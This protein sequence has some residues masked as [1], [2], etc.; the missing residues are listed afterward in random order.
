MNG[1]LAMAG[2]LLMLCVGPSSAD[3]IRIV[4]ASNFSDTAKELVAR[5]RSKTGHKLSLITGSTGKLYAQ[6]IHGAPFDVFFAA[7]ARRPERLEQDGIAV[8][9]SRFT[10]ASGR[11]VL[12]SP[13][14]GLVDADGS[15]LRSD[16]F[17]YLAIANPKLAPYGRAAEQLLRKL[18]LWTGLRGR[19]V[20]GENIGQAFG[21][22]S[23]GNADLGLVAYSQV[24]S[25]NRRSEGSLWDVPASLYDPIEQQVVQLRDNA[26]SRAFMDFVKG[27]EARAIIRGYG[28]GTP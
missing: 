3:E 12:W 11:L 16:R 6:I 13:K 10:Y 20:R 21:F 26:A 18:G 4:V 19:M 2:A 25:P 23:S 1:V 8:P 5:F 27:D 7:D 15:V 22:V 14:P 24:M 17:H 28:Y 9:G